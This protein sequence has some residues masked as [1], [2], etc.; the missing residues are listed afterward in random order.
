MIT[1]KLFRKT[2]YAWCKNHI[3]CWQLL[4]NMFT[5]KTVCCNYRELKK[6]WYIQ[7]IFQK[8]ILSIINAI[9]WKCSHLIHCANGDIFQGETALVY[10]KHNSWR[11]PSPKCVG[12]KFGLTM[13]ARLPNLPGSCHSWNIGSINCFLIVA[14]NCWDAWAI[15]LMLPYGQK[16]DLM[17]C[18]NICWTNGG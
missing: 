10:P 12:N 15:V 3:L 7:I 8:T 17:Y 11:I 18:F 2:G 6:C 4:Q 1:F 13:Q 9:F 5:Q 16:C 14:M